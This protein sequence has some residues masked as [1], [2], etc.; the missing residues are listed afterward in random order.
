MKNINLKICAKIRSEN[1]EIISGFN[2]V[3]MKTINK[4]SK[5]V[6]VEV[7]NQKN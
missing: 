6:I 5:Q 7:K 3:M 4:I 2:H 1:D